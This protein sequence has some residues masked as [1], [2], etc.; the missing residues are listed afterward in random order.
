[1]GTPCVGFGGKPPKKHQT[2]HRNRKE[3]TLVVLTPERPLN[4]LGIGLVLLISQLNIIKNLPRFP[5]TPHP[6]Q[7]QEKHAD[8]SGDG[9]G[10]NNPDDEIKPRGRGSKQ[11]GVAVRL[12]EV[13]FD[14]LLGPAL[15]QPVVDDAAHAYGEG[16]LG[17]VDAFAG[18]DRAHD[19]LVDFVSPSL[20]GGKAVVPRTC[21]E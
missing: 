21:C 12:D 15:L 17:L 11:H 3:P 14:L 6:P 18:A 5:T 8:A 9:N 4:A 13:V 19:G 7:G 16:V 20:K 1:M 2:N 10:R